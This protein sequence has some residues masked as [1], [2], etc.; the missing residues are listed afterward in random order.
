MKK[1]FCSQSLSQ[2]VLVTN[3]LPFLSLRQNHLLCCS[4]RLATCS[5]LVT[6]EMMAS[7]AHVMRSLP[8]SSP[9]RC[10]VPSP[11]PSFTVSP[12]AASP[13]PAN[14]L[15]CTP[16]KKRFL[17]PFCICIVTLSRSGLMIRP[18]SIDC[19]VPTTAAPSITHNSH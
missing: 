1:A 8:H 19:R 9:V 11:E 5:G 7:P 2:K 12:V 17:S 13:D 18:P 10:G 4:A 3:L 16:C 15:F 14:A 6:Q